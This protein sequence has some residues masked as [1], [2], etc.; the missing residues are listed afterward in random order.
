MLQGG[1]Y[2]V[3]SDGLKQYA[4][5][6]DRFITGIPCCVSKICDT[7]ISLPGAHCRKK[8][9]YVLISKH[10]HIH[11]RKNLNLSFHNLSSKSYNADWAIR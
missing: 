11:Q 6:S 4:F 7:V 10:F 5:P 3:E 9:Q 1:S 8:F 2:H